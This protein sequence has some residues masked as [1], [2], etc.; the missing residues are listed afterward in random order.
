[1]NKLRTIIF[2]CIALLFSTS[3]SANSEQIAQ[4]NGIEI[5]Y[6]T[7]GSQEDPALL[8]I[9]GACSQGVLWPVELCEQFANLEFYVI[10]YD[11]RDIGLSTSFD[12]E[13]N[14]YD[15]L[16]LAKDGV[17]LLDFLQID[18]AHLFG[19]SMGGP[20]A[21][22]IA[23]NF[24]ERVLTMSLIATSP[25]FRPM[26]LALAGLPPEENVLS[27]PKDNY[28][29]SMNLFLG[30][31]PKNEEEKLKQRV[32][33]WQILNGSIVPLEEKSQRTIHQQFLS[34]QKN[35]EGPANHVRCCARS[36]TLIQRVPYQVNIPTLVMHGSEDP[37]FGPDHGFALAN[38]IPGSKFIF[39]EGMG[40]VPNPHFFDLIVTEVA[41]LAQKELTDQKQIDE[42]S[43]LKKL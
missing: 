15:V 32:A 5:C 40:H 2:S 20:I 24:P 41:A 13:K 23:A 11:H 34:R 3:L 27:R 18:Q 31:P 43:R 29:E 17:G 21:E 14:P 8:L 10:R 33:L 25:D 36:E 35:A 9:I 37:I 6:E 30:S 16:D 12:F 38:I 1:M 28:L 39:I 22:L 42:A 4:S 7:F 26:N 19:L